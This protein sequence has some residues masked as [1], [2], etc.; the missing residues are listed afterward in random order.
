MGALPDAPIHGHVV[1]PEQQRVQTQNLAVPRPRDA[2]PFM[3]T[4]SRRLASAG[5]ADPGD[6]KSPSLPGASPGSPTILRQGYGLASRRVVHR[7]QQTGST[8]DRTALGVQ[9]S[10]RRP[11]WNVNRTSGPD[12]FA[13][14]WAPQTGSVVRVHGIPPFMLASRALA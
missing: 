7:E 11:F 4:I 2:S 12:L 6:L 14:Q 13:K 9:V 3:P 1:K 10:P 5:I 8:Q